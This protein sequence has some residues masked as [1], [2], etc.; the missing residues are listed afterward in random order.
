M[1]RYNYDTLSGEAGNDIIFG[2]DGNDTL[3][4][5]VG[6]DEL[7]AGAGNDELSG[8]AGND[9]LIG[10]DGNDTLFSGAGNDFLA[11]GLGNDT[12][13]GGGGSDRF[14]FGFPD[15]GVDIITDFSSADDR[16]QVEDVDF[17]GGL[18]P[19]SITAAQF[20]LGSSAQD[21]SDRFIY[22]RSTGTLFFDSDGT[23]NNTQVQLATLS[24][25]PFYLVSV[26]PSYWRS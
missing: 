6:N 22:N 11:G 10:E 14:Y 2:D 24:G 17:G 18:Q 25:S 19:G 8:G 23:G 12:L 15:E 21:T 3:N 16:L 4:G 1:K 5:G 13:T 26:L 7:Y 9:T 20:R